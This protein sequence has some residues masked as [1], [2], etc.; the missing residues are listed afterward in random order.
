MDEPQH[1]ELQRKRQLE[2]E[3]DKLTEAQRKEF[4]RTCAILRANETYTTEYALKA[5]ELHRTESG[6]KL[7]TDLQAL[8]RTAEQQGR[9]EQGKGFARVDEQRELAAKTLALKEA[10]QRQQQALSDS[11]RQH[12]TDVIARRQRDFETTQF[13]RAASGIDRQRHQNGQY[14]ELRRA[15]E[16]EAPTKESDWQRVGREVGGNTMKPP[17]LKM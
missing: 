7:R 8:Y 4:D 1:E 11:H 13:I 14:N 3:R 16:P 15:P 12:E 9:I 17:S 10:E 6:V 5:A 2:A